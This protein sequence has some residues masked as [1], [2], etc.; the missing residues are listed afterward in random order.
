[1]EYVF[2]ERFSQHALEKDFGKQKK[3]GSRSE[4]SDPKEF[5]YNGNTNRLQTNVSHT[6]GNT[7]GRFDRKRRWD[8]VTSDKVP[9][10]QRKK[11]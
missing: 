1:M 2:T 3:I 5:G 11:M 4:N 6:S 8:N 9:K 7:R 10:K